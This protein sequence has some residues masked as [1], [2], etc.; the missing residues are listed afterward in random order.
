MHPMCFA[1][2]GLFTHETLSKAAKKARGRRYA[3][4]PEEPLVFDYDRLTLKGS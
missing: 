1:I 2:Y 4:D 3:D